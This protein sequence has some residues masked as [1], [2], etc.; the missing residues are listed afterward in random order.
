[1]AVVRIACRERRNHP[2]HHANR[3]RLDHVQSPAGVMGR[4]NAFARNLRAGELEDSTGKSTAPGSRALLGPYHGE[5][6]G[7][8]IFQC[9]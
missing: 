9:L 4:Y 1:V 2:S 6:A 8:R 5:R 7:R 3:I